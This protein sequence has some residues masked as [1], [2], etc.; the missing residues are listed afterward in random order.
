MSITVDRD[1]SVCLFQSEYD[2]YITIDRVHKKNHTEG[3]QGIELPT[4]SSAVLSHTNWAT[5]NCMPNFENKLYMCEIIINID[6]KK[7]ALPL[8]GVL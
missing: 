5:R 4:H 6:K 1:A 8:T 3:W 2:I 7:W